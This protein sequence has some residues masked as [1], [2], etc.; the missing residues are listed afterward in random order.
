MEKSSHY[1]IPEQY[2]NKIMKSGNLIGAN[3]YKN[4]TPYW[5]LIFIYPLRILG[6]DTLPSRKHI[7]DNPKENSTKHE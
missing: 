1:E 3:K 2:I 7:P 4:K 5:C 6:S